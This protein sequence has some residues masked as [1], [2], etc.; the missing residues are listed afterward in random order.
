M[1]LYIFICVA[2]YLL[3]N[4]LLSYP[5]QFLSKIKHYFWR[6]NRMKKQTSYTHDAKCWNICKYLCIQKIIKN[7]TRCF[8]LWYDHPWKIYRLPLN[9]W[10]CENAQLNAISQALLRVPCRGWCARSINNT[11]YG[12]LGRQR[13]WIAN[14]WRYDFLNQMNRKLVFFFCGGVWLWC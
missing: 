6:E 8:T 4:K 14:I 12:M 5:I 11:S 13:W 1:C 10:L 2:L 9:W 3:V 7:E